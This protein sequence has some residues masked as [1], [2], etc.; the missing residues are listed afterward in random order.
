[1]SLE[2]RHY[3]KEALG[4]GASKEAILETLS[5]SGWSEQVIRKTLEQFCGVDAQGVP[6][7]AP[8][9]QAHQIARDC[10]VYLLSFVTLCMSAIALGALLFELINHAIPD[11]ASRHAWV[12]RANSISWAIAQLVV[13]LPCYLGLLRLIQLEIAKHP[14]KRE[15]LI[16]KLIIY[17]ILGITAVIGLGDLISTLTHFLQGELTWRFLAKAFVVMGISLVIFIYYLSEMRQDDRLIQQDT[18]Q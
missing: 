2:L 8:R 5:R 4:R 13:T 1:M 3:V 17:A 16:R 14:E 9:M 7:P 18:P 15:S 6:I 11:P 12:G 10:F